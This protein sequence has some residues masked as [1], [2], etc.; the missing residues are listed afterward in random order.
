MLQPAPRS[1]SISDSKMNWGTC[2]VLPQPVS[3]DIII[4]YR[5]QIPPLQGKY[6][7][8]K[9]LIL[10]LQYTLTLISITRHKMMKNRTPGVINIKNTS[11]FSHKDDLTNKANIIWER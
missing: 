10:L 3:P 7:L 4:T 8:G 5:I 2:V 11:N 1:D 9:L 6:I